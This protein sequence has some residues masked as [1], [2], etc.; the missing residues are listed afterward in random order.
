MRSI[1]KIMLS[2]LLAVC[3][4][5]AT[6]GMSACFVEG[7][8]M[9]SSSS[10]NG[11]SYDVHDSLA[12][13]SF[14]QN[15]FDKEESSSDVESSIAQESSEQESSQQEI[16]E[17]ESFEQ[18]SSSKEE[19]SSGEEISTEEE[20]S[21]E[22][23]SSE[24][25]PCVEHEWGEAETVTEAKCEEVGQSVRQCLYCEET[26]TEE[27]P[28]LG[29]NYSERM[30]GRAATCTIKEIIDYVC[31]NGTCRKFYSVE[32]EVDPD[33]HPEDYLYFVSS[34]PATCIQIGWTSGIK[35]AGCKGYK[36]APQERGYG[37][38][39]EK[40]VYGDE[41]TCQK[42]GLTNGVK[43]EFC[44]EVLTPQE[45]IPII[46]HKYYNGKCYM[47][48]ILE[49]SEDLAFTLSDDGTYYKLTG[50]GTCKDTTVVIPDRYEGLPVTEIGYEAFFNN[51]TITE[52][53]IPNSVTLIK[54][55]AFEDCA[56]LESVT[57]PEGITIING[58][59]FKGTSNLR[60]ITLP[61]TLKEIDYSAFAN[62]GLR[63]V[64]FP[65]GM[66]TIGQESFYRC[67]NLQ[68][69]TF[70]STIKSIE[71]GAF[72]ECTALK[73]VDVGDGVVAILDDAFRGCSLLSSVVIGE[74]VTYIGDNAFYYTILSS[75]VFKVPEGWYKD[76]TYDV[77]YDFSNARNAASYLTMQ[78]SDWRRWAD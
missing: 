13:E 14:W 37:D 78:Y 5:F 25:E 3:A 51:K 49:P 23:S 42:E 11:I 69:I 65:E 34:I 57:I 75:A 44:S 52:V 30:I 28:A 18:E 2:C 50:I 55:S 24:Q 76:N 1:Q 66:E 16:S 73:S 61:T 36:E 4:M 17:E 29:H 15:G 59:T 39:R 77:S 45:V 47:C 40:T 46:D 60:T 9:S 20:S 10:S 8:E 38:H 58:S 7:G 64:A 26:L 32:G 53:Q 27:I 71:R 48:G 67:S 54:G 6:T 70:S 74:S 22:E 33:N 63:E 68:K 19:I 21:E 41:A 62:S 56:Y 12:N 35:C 43:C 72:M 31:T